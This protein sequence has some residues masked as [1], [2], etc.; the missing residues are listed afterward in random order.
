MK[1][2]VLIPCIVLAVLSARA[3]AQDLNLLKNGAFADLGSDKMPAEWKVTATDQTIAQDKTQ[4]P[5]KPAQSVSVELK[6]A[7][8]GQGALT[9]TIKTPGPKVRLVLTAQLKGTA[10]RLGY[11]QVK[12]KKQGKE[13]R[14]E[15]SEWNSAAWDQRK[16]EFSTD[17]ADELTIECRFSQSDK[18]VGQTIWFA[19]VKLVEVK[20]AT[21]QANP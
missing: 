5:E 6:K 21:T 10:E 1:T 15:R 20:A 4:H 14:R 18:A 16:V 3:S 2:S 19:D 7:A 9:Q 17:D 12:L 13:L 11:V 8:E